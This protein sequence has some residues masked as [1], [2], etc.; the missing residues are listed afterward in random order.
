M[1]HSPAITGEASG[2]IWVWFLRTKCYSLMRNENKPRSYNDSNHI[3]FKELS[4]GRSN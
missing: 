1:L 3:I 2:H 4:W